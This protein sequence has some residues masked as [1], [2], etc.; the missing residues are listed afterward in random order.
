MLWSTNR[1]H[2]GPAHAD[3]DRT[4]TA[5]PVPLET[6]LNLITLTAVDAS[7]NEAST[8]L[9]VNLAEPEPVIFVSPLSMPFGSV[10]VGSASTLQSCDG[11]QRRDGRT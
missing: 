7:S 1:G 3:R 11:A 8:S 10:P 2:A 9:T 4:W 5:S 6:G